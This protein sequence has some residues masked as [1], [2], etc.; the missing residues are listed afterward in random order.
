MTD[1][2]EAG[3]IPEIGK[4]AALLRLDGLD[5]AIVAFQKNTGAVRLLPQGQPATIPAQPGELLDEFVFADALECGEPRDFL[6]RQT[7]LPRPATASRATLAFQKNGHAGKVIWREYSGNLKIEFYLVPAYGEHVKVAA[8]KSRKSEAE[9]LDQATGNLLHAVKQKLVKK[10][11]RVDYGKL[12]KD[13][14]S[15]RF[16]AKLEEA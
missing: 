2:L 13:G 4:L 11:G 14:Y 15:D 1:F 12:R 10:Q 6:I 5:R 7:H 9:L 3:K 16:L 8:A